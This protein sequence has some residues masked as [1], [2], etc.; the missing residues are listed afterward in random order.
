MGVAIAHDWPM[1]R[2]LAMNLGIVARRYRIE[3][4]QPAFI[5]DELEVATF[6]SDAKRSSATRH[7][8]IHRVHDQAL[9]VRANVLW[10]WI[11]LNTRRPV[12]IPDQFRQ[13]FAA[14]IATS[15]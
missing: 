6:V 8:T 9:L 3:Y 1:E 15:I 13:D 10:V 7:Y 12:R 5:G 11:D 2:L 14:N 4:R